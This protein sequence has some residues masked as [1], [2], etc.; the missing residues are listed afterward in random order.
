MN[1]FIETCFDKNGKFREIN[2]E[3]I[4]SLWNCRYCPFSG[5]PDLCSKGLK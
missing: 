2:Y 4:P 5:K 3:P 1:K